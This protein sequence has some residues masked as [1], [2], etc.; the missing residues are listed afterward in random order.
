MIVGPPAMFKDVEV[1]TA[2]CTLLMLDCTTKAEAEVARKLITNA[3]IIVIV[4]G[5]L[6]LSRFVKDKLD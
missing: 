3:F 2:C 4:I 1:A 5:T 6:A